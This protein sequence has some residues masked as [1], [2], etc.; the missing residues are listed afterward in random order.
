M[1]KRL[2][3][4]IIIVGIIVSVSLYFIIKNLMYNSLPNS[5]TKKSLPI[6][7]KTEII[8]IKYEG[9]GKYG[10]YNWMIKQ[11]KYQH[12][13]FIFNDGEELFI[14]QDCSVGGG[15]AIIRPYRC[16]NPQRAVG[17]P[18]GNHKGGYLSL[19]DRAKKY[20]DQALLKAKKLIQTK[21]YNK[22][23]FNVDKNCTN[24]N[25]CILGTH[26]FKVG[27]DVKK[28]ITQGIFNLV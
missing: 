24:I 17:I 23:F 26:I 1:K 13:L 16:N 15:N 20:I 27:E 28:Y 10:D 18:T 12:S 19:T 22:V 25:N 14:N 7:S 5:S 21:H 3:I 8:P 11:P 2:I 9:D 6:F 4:I